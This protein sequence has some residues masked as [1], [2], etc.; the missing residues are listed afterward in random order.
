MR[1]TSQPT[2][3]YGW[4]KILWWW[5][6][7]KSIP[8]FAVLSKNHYLQEVAD[9]WLFQR[10]KKRNWRLK[11]AS[12]FNM[13]LLW[14]LKQTKSQKD[15]NLTLRDMNLCIIPLRWQ[16]D[17][18]WRIYWTNLSTIP[19]SKLKKM[20]LFWRRHASTPQKSVFFCSRTSQNRTE[21]C[22]IIQNKLLLTISMG[23]FSIRLTSIQTNNLWKNWGSKAKSLRL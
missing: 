21:L 7:P 18:K 2:W 3:L 4:P 6:F 8:T 13:V 10:R 16:L 22:K 1:K 14:G 9:V 20:K 11:W 5:V 15:W 17:T 12:T 19:S 23:F